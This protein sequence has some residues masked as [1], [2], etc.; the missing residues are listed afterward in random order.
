M[1]AANTAI[2]LL[3]LL[4]GFV[5]RPVAQPFLPPLLQQCLSVTEPRLEAAAIPFR[6][7]YRPIRCAPTVLP[8]S[9]TL[10]AP[11]IQWD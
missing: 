11:G 8:S 7:E 5:I 9:T 1:A 10:H 2:A 6:V 4:G 3:S